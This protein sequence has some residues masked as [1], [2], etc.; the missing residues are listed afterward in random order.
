MNKEVQVLG[1]QRVFHG[2]GAAGRI[3]DDL[4][5]GMLAK[6]RI[7]CRP[8][9]AF[10]YFKRFFGTVSNSNESPGALMAGRVEF[11][12]LVPN[13]LLQQ[14]RADCGPTRNWIPSQASALERVHVRSV[15]YDTPRFDCYEAKLAA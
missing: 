6:C 7:E 1:G 9:T 15:L 11:K 13:S 2:H 10:E 3:P 14:V 8:M 12:Y 5:P 4:M